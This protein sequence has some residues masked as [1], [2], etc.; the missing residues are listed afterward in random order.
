MVVK[1]NLSLNLK[2]N[3]EEYPT[4]Q[5]AMENDEDLYYEKVFRE[6][7]N[8]YNTVGSD[9]ISILIIG[10]QRI[11]FKLQTSKRFLKGV[12]VDSNR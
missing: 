12:M 7:K 1:N 9:V 10:C 2:N 5:R 11:I 8:H 3:K 6:V 4:N